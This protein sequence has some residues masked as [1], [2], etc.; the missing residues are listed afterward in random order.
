M[1]VSS[2]AYELAVNNLPG[3]YRLLFNGIE[4]DGFRNAEPA[5][6]TIGPT[7]FFL[8]RHEQR[9]GLEVL[10]ASVAILPSDAKVWVAG[11]GPQTEALKARYPDDRIEWLGRIDD[12]ERDRRMRRR[13]CSAH[14]RSA[15]SPSV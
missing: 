3:D 13:R 15:A 5:R 10:L 8:G 14:P 11:T 1:A 7:V 12:A 9:K 6:P 2:D 4:I